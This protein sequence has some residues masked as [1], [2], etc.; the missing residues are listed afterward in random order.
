MPAATSV[1]AV[2][3][4][5][6]NTLVRID[7]GAIADHL[8][9]H[10]VAVSAEALQRAEQRARV[11][12]DADL[13]AVPADRRSTETGDTHSR[14]LRYTLHGAGITDEAV[15]AAVGEWRR[16][17]NSPIGL[18]NT[19]DPDAVRALEMTRAAGL[20]AAVISNSNG[21]IRTLLERL[22][23]LR[24][25]DVVLDSGE[26]GVEKPNP[27]IFRRALARAGVAAHEAVYI[28][29]LYS[30]DVLGAQGAGLRAILLDPGGHWGE[31]DCDTAPTVLEAVRRIIGAGGARYE[32]SVT[33]G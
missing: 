5:V 27:E 11:R 19:P 33:N 9:V 25:I 23:L 8:A 6:G 16:T 31:R 7:Y 32:G 13:G 21:T 3:F 4:D 17:Y 10:G 22:D 20:K 1:R 30:I 12:L 2:F 18:W 29:D 28:G 26:E 24:L 14:Y 15:I